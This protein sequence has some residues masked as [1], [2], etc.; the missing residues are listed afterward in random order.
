MDLTL[1]RWQRWR[2]SHSNIQVAVE[3]AIT[4]GYRHIDTAYCY[5][6]EGDVGKALK[7]KMNQGVVKREDMFVV[8][9]VGAT[10]RWFSMNP[11]L[12]R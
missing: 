11:L 1:H 10:D 3:T 9:K 5:Q 12:E 6:S 8:S 2:D 7:S 4:T